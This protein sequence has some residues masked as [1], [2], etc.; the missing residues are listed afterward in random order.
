MRIRWS[1]GTEI[2]YKEDE[3]LVVNNLQQTSPGTFRTEVEPLRG[4]YVARL[5]G[6]WASIKRGVKRQ[7]EISPPEDK[8]V[9]V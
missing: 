6:R 1:K 8:T 3:N 5:R 4:L 2:V 7:R 9:K